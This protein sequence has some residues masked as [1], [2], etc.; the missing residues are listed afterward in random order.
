MN[1]LQRTWGFVQPYN[2]IFFFMVITAI[3]PV[4][5]ELAVPSA[6]RYVIDEGI[7]MGDMQAI[8]ST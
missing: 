5:M 7:E 2:I 3:L 4:A 1:S 8:V 6:L